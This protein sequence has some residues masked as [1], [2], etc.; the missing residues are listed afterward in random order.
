MWKVEFY[1]QETRAVWCSSPAPKLRT[2]EDAEQHAMSVAV[3]AAENG[4]RLES[5]IYAPDGSL[6]HEHL[7]P[8]LVQTWN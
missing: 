3:A 7:P 2:L 8:R 5:R 4:E 1:D 6:H